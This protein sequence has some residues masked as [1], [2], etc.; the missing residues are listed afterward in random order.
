MSN[1]KKLNKN[2]GIR[3]KELR[4]KR[5]LTQKALADLAYFTPQFISELERGNRSLTA[6]TARKLAEALHA[7]FQYLLCE[8]DYESDWDAAEA[9]Y[10]IDFLRDLPSELL[11]ESGI[12]IADAVDREHWVYAGKEFEKNS[13]HLVEADLSQSWL[14][15][16]EFEKKVY[17]SGDD[18]INEWLKDVRDYAEM[19][20][21]RWLIPKCEE[22]EYDGAYSYAKMLRKHLIKNGVL[23]ESDFS[24]GDD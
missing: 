18:C 14:I 12:K 23:S 1:N 9:I 2:C 16:D 3:I 8:D 6:D 20:A 24:E 4:K 15:C 19:R 7:R 10:N 11:R 5:G 22:M 13:H 21:R 17:V